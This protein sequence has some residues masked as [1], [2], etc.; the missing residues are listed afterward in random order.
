MNDGQFSF[1]CS[2]HTRVSH[3]H[4]DTLDAY[5]NIYMH[6]H[7]QLIAFKVAAENITVRM[8]TENNNKSTYMA[9]AKLKPSLAAC[10]CIKTQ[11]M[12]PPGNYGARSYDFGE[13]VWAVGVCVCRKSVND[14]RRG[15]N[16]NIIFDVAKQNETILWH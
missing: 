15:N 13:M 9:K 16:S 5:T 11:H 6:T 10:S 12:R 7:T 4:I 8:K 1:D 3:S 2:R 14:G